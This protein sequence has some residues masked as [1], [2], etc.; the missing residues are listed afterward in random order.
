[1]CF[2]RMFVDYDLAFAISLRD[3]AGPLVKPRPIQP[4]KRRIVAMTFNAASGLNVYSWLSRDVTG[5]KIDGRF[6][7]SGCG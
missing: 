6:V 4:R 3:F 5:R 1:L 2:I 7:G